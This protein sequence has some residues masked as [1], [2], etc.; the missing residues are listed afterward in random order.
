MFQ[1]KTTTIAALG[2]ALGPFLAA[3]GGGETVQQALGF[4]QKGPD[5]MAVIKR[6]PLIVPPDYNL[7]PPS[8]E[9]AED[10]SEAASDAARRTLIGP[11]ASIDG[12]SND[13]RSLL[14]GT[15]TENADAEAASEGQNLLVSRSDRTERDLDALEGTRAENRVDGALLRR[16]LAWTP[17]DLAPSAEAA[18]DGEA[19]TEEAALVQVVS[20]SQTVIE[21]QTDP[22]Q[23][24]T[25]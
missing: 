22:D 8:P 1:S 12:G 13:S 11:D 20:R 23:T 4:E 5:E 10:G 25:E 21:P 7:R 6:P 2:L 17:G 3:C 24:S 19:E 9:E 15:S 16:L 14:T 18:A